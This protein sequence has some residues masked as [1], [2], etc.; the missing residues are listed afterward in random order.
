M[1]ILFISDHAISIRV[2]I[3]YKYITHTYACTLPSLTCVICVQKLDLFHSWSVLDLMVKRNAIVKNRVI[4]Q[5]IV[6]VK[7][8]LLDSMNVYAV[9]LVRLE[10]S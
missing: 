4:K 5:V 8:K 7:A 6:K 9:V 10:T 1:L 3:Q 2:N